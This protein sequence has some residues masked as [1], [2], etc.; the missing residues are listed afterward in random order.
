MPV[1]LSCHNEENEYNTTALK[2]TFRQVQL[3]PS[4]TNDHPVVPPISNKKL[5]RQTSAYSHISTDRRVTADFTVQ[6][7]K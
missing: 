7:F 4:V 1:V 6:L 5:I 2:I 3:R